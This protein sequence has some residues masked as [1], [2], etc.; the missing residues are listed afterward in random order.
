MQS[1][2]GPRPG[3]SGE[4]AGRLD[5]FVDQRLIALGPFLGQSFGV[6]P[7][8]VQAFRTEMMPR[9]KRRRIVKARNRQVH[10]L[11]ALFE[12]EAERCPA[13]TA[14]RPLGNR[15]ARIPVG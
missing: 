7:R 5:P 3:S 14:E 13:L 6:E 11:A 4:F 15:G 2:D 10:I 12:A 9:L 1:S 8:P